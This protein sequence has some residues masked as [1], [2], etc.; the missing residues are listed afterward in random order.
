MHIAVISSDFRSAKNWY[1]AKASPKCRMQ[2][3]YNWAQ[4][5]NARVDTQYTID[6]EDA[7]R[8]ESTTTEG[9]IREAWNKLA[10]LRHRAETKKAHRLSASD[11]ATF[12]DL[13][14]CIHEIASEF[15]PGDWN[16]LF[17][18]TDFSAIPLPVSILTLAFTER[19]EGRIP[20]RKVFVE[21]C[22]KAVRALGM[23]SCLFETELPEET[24]NSKEEMFRTA[25]HMLACLEE[26]TATNGYLKAA[27]QF[28]KAKEARW[29]LACIYRNVRYRIRDEQLDELDKDI[30]TFDAHSAGVDTMLAI[31][32]ATAPIKSKLPSRKSLYRSV[33]RELKNRPGSERGI[34]DGLK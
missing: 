19:E 33:R 28:E 13:C 34:L 25:A 18:Y 3:S 16:Q 22:R 14:S 31:L 12:E 23:T 11:K 21:R 29:A 26:Q 15:G 10:F 30:R 4:W 7:A 27:S 17:T 1:T 8:D 9:R 2:T 32:T 6:A 5:V 20:S 24:S